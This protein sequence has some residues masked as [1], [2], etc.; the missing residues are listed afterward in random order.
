M[1]EIFADNH[2]RGERFGM[3]FSQADEPS[4]LLLDNYPWANQKT[5]V[6]VGGSHGSIA[7]RIAQNFPTV[8]CIVQD[9]PDT[10]AEGS[11]RLPNDLRGRVSFMAQ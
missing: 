4:N 5:V 3:L 9:L 2:E 1:Y 6:D 11:T 10:A 8:V 7:I